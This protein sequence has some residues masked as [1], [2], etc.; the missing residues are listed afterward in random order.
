MTGNTIRREYPVLTALGIERVVG[1]A[2]D[3]LMAVVLRP[4][5]G[6]KVLVA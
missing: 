3:R 5:P 1:I 4:R 6:G 2:H